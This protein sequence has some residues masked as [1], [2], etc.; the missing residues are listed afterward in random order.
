[1][2]A[3]DR[4]HS[5]TGGKLPPLKILLSVAILCICWGSSFIAVR[6]CLDCFPP[7]TLN[8]VRFLIAGSLLYGW[9]RFRGEPPMDARGWVWSF[10]V[11]VFLF[12]GGAGFLCVGQQ[13][14]ASGLSA[15]LIATVPLWAVLFAAF[16]ERKPTGREVVG[17]LVGFAGVALLNLNRGLQG[18][19]LGVLTVLGAA[20]TWAVGSIMNR[21]LP[22]VKGLRG[23]A[24]QMIAGGVLV[25]PVALLRGERI[26]FPL[27]TT[28][29]LGELHLI[30]MGGV[31][32]FS[33]FVYLLSHTRPSVA[34]SYAFIN[35]VIAAFLGWWL[36]GETVSAVNIAAMIVILAG[37]ALVFSGR[38]AED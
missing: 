35:P 28:V 22:C 15:T 8:A 6:F 31:V 17:L 10:V 12:L 21:R 16:V 3:L 19:L 2:G 36:A 1:M 30:I 23:A 14:I 20:A 27:T 25:L 38:P 24:T 34:T 18:E 9:S 13:W 7:Y 32:G 4:T 5:Q 29:I 26:L 37:V 11:A 33:V